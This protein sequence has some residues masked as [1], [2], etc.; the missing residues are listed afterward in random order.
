[1]N[2]NIEKARQVGE[3][4]VGK[5]GITRVWTQLSSGKFDWRKVKSTGSSN[6][7]SKPDSGGD[8]EEQ[9]PTTKAGKLQAH[10]KKTTN[11][12]LVSFA[13]NPNNDPSL[14][15]MAYDELKERGEDVSDIDLNTGKMKQAK[16][17]FGDGDGKKPPAAPTSKNTDS[18]EDE[19][20]NWQDVDNIK[21]KFNNG[22]TKKDRIEMDDYIHNLKINDPDYQ[23]PE[24][25][26]T[27][28]NK[29]YAQ[30]LKGGSPLM[31]ASGGAGVGKSY[32]FHAVAKYMGKKPFD[33]ETDQPGDGDYD[34][35]EAP[36]VDSVPQF[37][38]LLQ[39]HNGKTIVFDDSD[40]VIKNPEIRGLFKK[41]TASS[42]KRIVGK[43]STNKASNVDPFEFTGQIL[44]ITNMN[45]DDFTKDEHMNAIYSRAIKKDIQFTKREKLH[46]VDK[47]K[48]QM[49]FTGVPRLDDKQ[50]DIKERDAVF[51][52]LADNIDSIDPQ[53]FNTR[54]FKEA[55][56]TKRSIDNANKMIQDDPVMGKM[57]FGDEEDWEK[58]VEKFIVKGIKPE[59][60]MSLEKALET[61]DL[62]K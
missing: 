61:L 43:K 31:I 32:N 35:F 52:I 62:L 13:T 33:P 22:K 24:K 7:D 58:E 44:L 57:L 42:G 54:T 2:K 14:R 20:K 56:E 55:I 39:E 25:E 18:D 23:P 6:K 29:T 21:K 45:Q 37:A 26:V 10:L 9:T 47:L 49:N 4:K 28:L 51:K 16:E 38:K 59:I 15:Q 40:M 53:K 46:F 8:D 34:Y 1:M 48:H 17:M 19:A 27:V 5:D 3:T 30:F 12:K 11:D 50:E 36:E 60:G 41:A